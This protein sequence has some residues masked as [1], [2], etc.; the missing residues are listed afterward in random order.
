MNRVKLVLTGYLTNRI[1]GLT[2]SKIRM[3]HELTGPT[4]WFEPVYKTMVG[5]QHID[6]DKFRCLKINVRDD[7]L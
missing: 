2:E 1:Y 6:M 3:I 4:G 7:R 5:N